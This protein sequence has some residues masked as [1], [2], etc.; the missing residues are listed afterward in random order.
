M[1]RITRRRAFAG[2]PMVALLVTA[3]LVGLTS[4][5]GAQTTPHALDHYMCYP[6]TA[7][8]AGPGDLTVSLKDQFLQSAARIGKAQNLCAPANKTVDGVSS[9][10]KNRV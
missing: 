4:S 8:P 9:G 10:V 3:A 1:S 2:V 7:K 6:I 5:S